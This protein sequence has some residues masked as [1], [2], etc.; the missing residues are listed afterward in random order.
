MKSAEQSSWAFGEVPM[1]RSTSKSR[2]KRVKLGYGRVV[3]KLTGESFGK[4]GTVGLDPACVGELA[5]KLISARNTGVQIAVVVG[6]GN[7]IRG[8]DLAGSELIRPVAAH[9]MGM[10]ATVINALALCEAL[11][12]AG[13]PA[14]LTCSMPAGN[15]TELY[16]PQRAQAHLA[17]G[18]IVI[19]AGGTG[20]SFVTTDTCAAI[21]AADLQAD[22]V[23]KATKVDGV[24]SDDPVKNRKARRHN[25]LTYGQVID[26][27]LGVM[28]LSAVMICQQAKI[29]IVVFNFQH[30]DSIASVL[31]GS[32]KAT[33][34]SD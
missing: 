9:Q 17:K 5:E 29:P 4:I 15:F 12:A 27:R 25:K 34:I 13:C 33:I 23:L 2:R 28:D 18:K 14:V 24:Y 32:V 1:A 3:V 6:A 10:T 11:E 19:L 8:A 22:A 21:R 7:W 30:P 16:N 31:D 20:N 26:G